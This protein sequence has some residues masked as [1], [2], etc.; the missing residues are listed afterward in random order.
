LDAPECGDG[1]AS[2]MRRD[3]QIIERLSQEHR[4]LTPLP[5]NFQASRIAALFGAIDPAHVAGP[6]FLLAGGLRK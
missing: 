4:K 6:A 2:V 1:R 5:L 3:H